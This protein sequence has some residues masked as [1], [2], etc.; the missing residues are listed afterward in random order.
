MFRNTVNHR[1]LFTALLIV[2]ILIS[3]CGPNAED[4]A[5]ASIPTR[6][7]IPTL[8]LEEINLGDGDN[9]DQVELTQDQALVLTLEANPTTGYVWEVIEID[10][11]VLKQV[12]DVLYRMSDDSPNPPPGTGGTKTWRFEPVAAGQTTLKLLWHQPW[13]ENLEPAHTFWVTVTVH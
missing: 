10:E 13:N 9:G 7:A 12:G 2:L 1:A 4:A 8:D 3:S 5:T 6:T 11:S